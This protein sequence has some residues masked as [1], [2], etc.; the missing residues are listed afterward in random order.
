MSETHSTHITSV[1]AIAIT[2]GNR[3][4]VVAIGSVNIAVAKAL[5]RERHQIVW[6]NLL[7]K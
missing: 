5:T 6:Y 3:S 2:F 4:I 7:S 1:I